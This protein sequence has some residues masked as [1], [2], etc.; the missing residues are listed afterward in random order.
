MECQYNKLV[1]FQNGAVIGMAT[2]VNATECS[3]R[4]EHLR[5]VRKLVLTASKRNTK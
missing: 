4:P 3:N 5:Q 2:C 1:L